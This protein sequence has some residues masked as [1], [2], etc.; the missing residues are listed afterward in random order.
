MEKPRVS[1]ATARTT[2]PS[3]AKTFTV[4]PSPFNTVKFE[5]GVILI[6]GI[7]LV[8][9]QSRITSSPTLQ[10]LLVSVYGLL[11]MVWIVV[12][13]RRISVQ[14]HSARGRR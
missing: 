14:L 12:R 10:F 4:A 1:A 11:G 2:L 6:L 9:V 5:L 7:L 13:T 3:C 8:L